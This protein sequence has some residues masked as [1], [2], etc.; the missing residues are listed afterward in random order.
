MDGCRQTTQGGALLPRQADRK[1]GLLPRL[2]ACFTDACEPGRIEHELGE[3]LAQRIDALALGYEDR[4]DPEELRNDPLLAVLAG[5]C[6]PMN[7]SIASRWTPRHPSAELCRI[8][9]PTVL[10]APFVRNPG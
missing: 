8:P 5:K 3:T 1:I 2:A 4:N 6:L 10:H 7:A 9:N